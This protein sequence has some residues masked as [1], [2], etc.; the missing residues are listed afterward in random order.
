MMWQPIPPDAK[1]P[2][3]TTVD[4]LRGHPEQNVGLRTCKSGSPAVVGGDGTITA[5]RASVATFGPN[6]SNTRISA[7]STIS[8]ENSI[9][10]GNKGSSFASF[11]PTTTGRRSAETL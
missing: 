8:G 11:F 9:V 7:R 5:F 2:V 6:T 3:G 1:L 10:A 4:V